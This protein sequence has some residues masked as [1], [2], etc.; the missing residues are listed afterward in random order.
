MPKEPRWE[1]SLRKTDAAFHCHAPSVKH[2]AK[3]I[4]TEL[5]AECPIAAPRVGLGI[6]FV[7]DTEIQELNRQYRGK[8]KPTDV[9]S[10][11]QVEGLPAAHNTELGDIVI[12]AARAKA[13]RKKF[14]T[15]FNQEILR[16]LIHGTLHLVGYDHENVPP[17]EGARM[18]KKE[19]EIFRKLRRQSVTIAALLRS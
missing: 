4:L 9:L 11:S 6:L 10:F 7:T 18:R 5:I 8:D 16:L 1:I 15:T 14:G 2:L 17:R 13:Q 19:L 3:L 12:S